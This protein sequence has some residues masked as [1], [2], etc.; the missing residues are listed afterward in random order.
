MNQIITLLSLSSKH[1]YIHNAW[2]LALNFFKGLNKSHICHAALG[3][4][5]EAET[6]S[7]WPWNCFLASMHTGK[8]A[9]R[10]RNLYGI[11]ECSDMAQWSQNHILFN[12]I[13]HTMPSM[14]PRQQKV[15][16]AD[17]SKVYWG[18]I[19][20]QQNKL[21]VYTLPNAKEHTVARKTLHSC[22]IASLLFLYKYKFYIFIPHLM[23]PDST[24]VDSGSKKRQYDSLKLN[25]TGIK[26]K[27]NIEEGQE[28]SVGPR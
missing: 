25:K 16:V 15:Q 20:W 19:P 10:S 23:F 18:H 8:G 24:G 5:K 4:T 12:I 26:G 14:G 1:T 27:T 9:V 21:E 13:I 7:T 3:E 28:F 22:W 17:L 6:K 2:H 11:C